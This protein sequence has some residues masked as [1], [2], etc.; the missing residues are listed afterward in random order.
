VTA[1]RIVVPPELAA[2][3]AKYHGEAGRAWV[4]ALPE[5]AVGYLDRWDLRLDGQPRHGVVALVLPV[6]TADGTRAVLK[7]SPI[8]EEHAGEAVALRAWDGDGAVR[9][10]DE[11][12]A[13]WTLLLERLDDSRSLADVPEV[14][15]AVQV[16]AALLARLTTRAAPP[17]IRG[18]GLVVEQ[19]VADAPAAAR[20]LA[21]AAERRLLARW[22]AAVSEVATEPGDRLLHWDLHYENV[23]AADREPWLAIDPKP[24]AGDPGFELLPALWN[25]WDEVVATGDVRRAVRRRF[26]LM[27]DM[28]GLDRQ[29]AVAWT[30]GRV[31]Q[32]SLWSVEDG[33]TRLDPVQITIA[34]AL[35]E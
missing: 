29:R 21:D 19:M 26:D 31:L 1:D 16:I 18:L 5:L 14:T 22:A 8:E 11:D 7:L 28:L 17:E 10:L 27:V 30:F 35:A 9:L 24:L 33:D 20:R 15:E 32:N 13:T 25:R 4:A 6:V 2:S 12:R 23:L 34:A 3:Q